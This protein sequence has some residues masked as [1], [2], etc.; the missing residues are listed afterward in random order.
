MLSKSL[1]IKL[2]EIPNKNSYLL[3]LLSGEVD[4]TFAP[5]AVA[6]PFIKSSQLTAIAYTGEKSS[7][8]VANLHRLSSMKDFYPLEL[9][10]GLVA[11]KTMPS[12]MVTE[13]NR[14]LNVV[15]TDEVFVSKL[16]G[17]GVTTFTKNSPND[18]LNYLK[19]EKKKYESLLKN[20]K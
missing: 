1:K 5:I 11:S 19:N 4:F 2:L 20:L 6:M 17:Q 10:Y 15:L 3:P 13:I 7:E 9:V 18:Y 12:E 8:L 14:L 16:S